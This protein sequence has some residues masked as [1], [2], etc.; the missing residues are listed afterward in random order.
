ML[1]LDNHY[2][3][4]VVI[5]LAFGDSFWHMHGAGTVW[6]S[7]SSTH[8]RLGRAA[9]VSL[10]FH[11]RRGRVGRH[12]LSRGL[13]I[14]RA[15]TGEQIGQV[16]TSGAPTGAT[17]AAPPAPPMAAITSPRPEMALP[18]AAGWW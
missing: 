14:G 8:W 17:A 15:G 10:L 7:R 18:P 5:P 12:A 11:Y 3:L 13:H 1:Q 16:R 2:F 6:A 4:Y 9:M